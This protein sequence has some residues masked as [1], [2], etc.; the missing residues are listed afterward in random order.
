MLCKLP[1][2]LEK[3]RGR[4]TC[5]NKSMREK[6]VLTIMLWF[7]FFLI[8]LIDRFQL[9]DMD[10]SIL[11][12]M[13]RGIYYTI[14]IGLDMK[15]GEVLRVQE[16]KWREE[17]RK[18][19]KIREDKRREQKSFTLFRCPWSEYTTISF[20]RCISRTKKGEKRMGKKINK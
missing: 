7:E 8:E 3:R 9:C 11:S 5:D 2:P 18:R 12:S 1:S 19:E 4:K 13:S 10:R 17:K 14:V 16:E 20:W 15:Y 6:K